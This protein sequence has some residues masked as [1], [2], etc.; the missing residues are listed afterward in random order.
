MLWYYVRRNC[1]VGWKCDAEMCCETWI[2]GSVL[3]VSFEI[4]ISEAEISSFRGNLRSGKGNISSV[5]FI[6]LLEMHKS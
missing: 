1:V 6:L 3:L 2:R 4:P 5:P